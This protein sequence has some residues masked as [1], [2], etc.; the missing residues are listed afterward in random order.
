[1][2][3]VLVTIGV[4]YVLSKMKSS[5]E[6]KTSAPVEGEIP[7]VNNLVDR[8]VQ[9]P[10]LATDVIPD[11]PPVEP[12]NEEDICWVNAM[13]YGCE[14]EEDCAAEEQKRKAHYDECV[15]LGKTIKYAY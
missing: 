15:R 14:K 2:D 12:V 9:T 3:P 10:T 5:A 11:L 13:P 6:A 1:M 8:I 7:P 4:L